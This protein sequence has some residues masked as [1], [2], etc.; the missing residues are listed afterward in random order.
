[1]IRSHVMLGKNRRKKRS[2]P[3][4][5]KS[6]HSS[7]I[8]VNNDRIPC[9]TEEWSSVVSIPPKVG[10]E[11][12]FTEFPDQTGLDLLD[13]IRTCKWTGNVDK[14]LDFMMASV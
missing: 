6:T 10:S 13:S 7:A 12:T 2:S 5:R 4:A 3:E 1:M 8:A 11:V 14:A 9:Q